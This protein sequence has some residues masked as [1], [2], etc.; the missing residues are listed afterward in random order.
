M[1]SIGICERMNRKMRGQGGY[2]RCCS[3]IIIAN[4]NC[5]QAFQSP[6]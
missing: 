5:V 3:E 6:R 2:N 4:M 1:L